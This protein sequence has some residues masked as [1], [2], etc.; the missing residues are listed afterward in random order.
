MAMYWPFCAQ[1]RPVIRTGLDFR[2]CAAG[3]DHIGRLA[4]GRDIDAV[5][6]WVLVAGF[7]GPA[8]GA[9]LAVVGITLD[10]QV[11]GW[12]CGGQGGKGSSG[13]KATSA[14]IKR[15]GVGSGNIVVI[16]RRLLR[17]DVCGILG[18]PYW[19]RGAVAIGAVFARRFTVRLAEGKLK[20]LA[21]ALG[22]TVDTVHVSPFAG[23]LP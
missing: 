7:D 12:R 11:L 10:T 19:L 18:Q 22:P 20:L 8:Q 13:S 5:V 15:M 6:A 17:A 14:G 16:E 1:G 2:Q 23:V 3:A 21:K 4:H 9:G